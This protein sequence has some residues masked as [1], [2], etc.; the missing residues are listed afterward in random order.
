MFELVVVV[1]LTQGGLV[2][3]INALTTY[4]YYHVSRMMSV[5]PLSQYHSD[6]VHDCNAISFRWN[7]NK[8]WL[9]PIH[10][11]RKCWFY[12]EFIFIYCLISIIIYLILW[13]FIISQIGKHKH[14]QKMQYSSIIQLNWVSAAGLYNVQQPKTSFSPIF[15]FTDSES[16]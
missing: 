16:N 8:M 10:L 15:R 7:I 3:D 5:L 4:T 2:F 14:N 1:T 6:G 12:D 11:Y 13:P 9:F